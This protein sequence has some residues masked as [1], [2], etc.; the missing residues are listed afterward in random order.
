M[1]WNIDNSRARIQKVADA[2]GDIEI[3]DLSREMD[4]SNV[5][6][7]KPK[8]ITGT[9]LYLGI[10][11]EQRLVAGLPAPADP[12]AAKA[13]A[14]QLHLFQRAVARTADHFG[15]ARIHFQGARLHAINYRPCS[16]HRR[17]AAVT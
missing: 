9:H 8:R 17:I 14:R 5:Q 11:N 3:T 16:D 2:L 1:G 15:L 10:A 12:D 4:L 6:R 7:R 13:P